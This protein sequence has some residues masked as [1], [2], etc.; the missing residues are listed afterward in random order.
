MRG[1]SAS[2]SSPPARR[3]LRRHGFA[4]RLAGCFLSV[5]AATCIIEFL[6]MWKPDASMFWVANGMLLGYLLLA[7]RW[8]WPAYLAAGLCALSVRIVFLPSR[9]H[10]FLLYGLLDIVEVAAAAQLLR[11]RSG[12]LPRFTERGYLVR[13]LFS[14]GL[15]APALAAGIYVLVYPLL[16]IAAPQHP[17]LSWMA[18]DGPGMLVSTPAFIAV[19]QTRFRKAV[20]WRKNWPYPILLV[21]VSMA[22][23]MQNSVPM[24]YLI[25]PLLVLV[26]LRLGLGHASLFMLI[27][28][29]IASWFTIRGSGPFAA[30]RAVN[31]ALPTVLL[32]VAAGA[33]MLMIYSVSVVLA[34]QKNTERRLQEIVALHTLVAENSR[35]VIIVADFEGNRKF[36]SSAV[37]S[38]TGWKL[39]EFFRRS[40]FELVHPEDRAD[41]QAAVKAIQA[42]SDGIVVEARLMRNTGEYIWAESSLRPIRD[43]V[44]GVPTGILNIMRDASDRKRSEEKLHEAYLALEE[45]AITDALTGLANRRRFDGS[46]ATEWRRALRDGRPLSLLLIDVDLFKSYNDTYGHPRGDVCLQQIAESALEVVARPGDV[47]ARFGGEEFAVLLPDTG[48][49]GAMRIAHALC[50]AVKGRKLTHSANGSGM[51]TVSVGCGTK[52]PRLG[53]D[54]LALI[55]AADQALYLAKRSGRDRVCN[56]STECRDADES[57]GGGTAPTVL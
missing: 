10:E 40:I 37:E 55:E 26:V 23:F 28:T 6:E 22:A 21:A 29:V 11:P 4:L 1:R 2:N 39:E 13:F 24:V 5:S 18:S 15:A 20:N 57:Q 44:S 46:L 36:V 53:E 3:W 47:V 12:M 30:A 16:S 51:V 49:E 17:F 45:L 33:A 7:P 48:N 9:W 43:P 19:F 38:I 35:D 50:A 34:N 56:G 31:P 42:G 52:I 54:S 8:R 41:A 25:Y 14:A 32:V 27:T